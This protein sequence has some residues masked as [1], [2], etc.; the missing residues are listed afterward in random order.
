MTETESETRLDEN[1]VTHL[2]RIH[3]RRARQGT[4]LALYGFMIL[5]VLG[6]YEFIST[7]WPRSGVMA[8]L[9]PNVVAVLDALFWPII[10]VGLFAL[11]VGFYYRTSELRDLRRVQEDRDR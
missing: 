6:S 11:V 2:E 10:V 9:P 4:R 8:V 5:W 7:R 1:A 3:Y